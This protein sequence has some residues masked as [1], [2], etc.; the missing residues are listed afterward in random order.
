MKRKIY[1]TTCLH[2]SSLWQEIVET[3]EKTR[4]E[5][6]MIV[7]LFYCLSKCSSPLY[8]CRSLETSAEP[9]GPLIKK[10]KEFQ[11][12]FALEPID[13][14]TVTLS[15]ESLESCYPCVLPG[16]R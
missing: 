6:N 8:T 11:I 14:F 13:L 7:L 4:L 2:L 10:K 16:E 1:I 15:H 12:I 5:G 3:S 9:F